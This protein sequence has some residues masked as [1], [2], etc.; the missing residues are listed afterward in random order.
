MSERKLHLFSFVWLKLLVV[1]FDMQFMFL[2]VILHLSVCLILNPSALSHHCIIGSSRH[3]IISILDWST[4]LYNSVHR[5][6]MLSVVQSS[7]VKNKSESL[8]QQCFCMKSLKTLQIQSCILL[9]VVHRFIYRC[10]HRCTESVT[11]GTS[12]PIFSPTDFETWRHFHG[13]IK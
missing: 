12:K 9:L 10:S 6:I 4:N 8:R 11:P 13:V 5:T 2:D 3:S 7:L 1:V